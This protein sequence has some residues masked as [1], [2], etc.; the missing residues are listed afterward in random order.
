MAQDDSNS[1]SNRQQQIKE[2]QV[3]K[4]MGPTSW[5]HSKLKNA[6]KDHLKIKVHFVFTVKHDRCHKARLVADG[7][8]T[9]QQVEAV[10][11]GVVSLRSLRI[12]MLL[13]ELNKL[14]LWGAD[15]SN[16]YL[17]ADTMEKLFII[18]GYEFDDLEGHILI[19]DKALYGTRTAGAW[20]DCLF[21]ILKQMGLNHSKAGQDVWMR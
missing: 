19:M 4:D 12:V 16:A 7:C 11:S 1:S 6:P 13:S 2:Y 3:F 10:Y 8:L 15:I 20:H 9:R 5:D 17:K 21:N 14:D 18:A